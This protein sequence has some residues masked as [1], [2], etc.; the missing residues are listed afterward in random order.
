MIDNN[1]VDN[2]VVYNYFY[3]I[4]NNIN[5][6]FYYG[7]H[8]TNNL[9]DGYMGS[10]VLINKAYKKYGKENFT[11]EIIKYFNTWED[12]YEYEA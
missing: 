3:K 6:K 10:G 2:N 9:N 8:C 4:T 1:V 11:K 12:A 7:V 5:N